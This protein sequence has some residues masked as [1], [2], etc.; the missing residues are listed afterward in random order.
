MKRVNYFDLGLHN[1]LEL[2]EFV[3]R[4]FP[5][6]NIDISNYFCYGFEACKKFADYNEY[7]FQ[8]YDNVKTYH[9]AISDKEEKIKLYLVDPEIQPGQVGNSI[10]RTKNNVTDNFEEVDSVIFS[11]WL[12]ENVPSFTEDLNIMKVN[13]EGAEFPLFK[14]MVDSD[15]LKYFPLIIGAGHDVDKVSELDS[16]EY[17][18]LIKGNNIKIER[19][20]SDYNE[21]KNCNVV[22]LINELIK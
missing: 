15:I 8:N 6:L 19:F 16:N 10:Y 20:C 3:L 7:S 12:K 11:K 1:G 21:E 2:R 14:D 13:I 5:T 17:W 4:I 9:K 22:N 18:E